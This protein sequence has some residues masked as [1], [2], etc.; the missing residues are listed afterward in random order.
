MAVKINEI[1]EEMNRIAPP[2]LAEEGDKIGFMVGDAE[3]FAERV[4][5]ALDA[6]ENVINEAIEKE[7]ELIITHHP[8]IY[9]PVSKICTD[10]ALGRKT[11]KLI[12][13]KMAVF[14]AHTNLDAADGGVNDTMCSLL[15]L[16]HVEKM[17]YESGT[18]IGRCGLLPQELTVG[19]LAEKLKN[20]LKCE[21]V[22]ICGDVNDKVEKV[23]MCCGGGAHPAFYKEAKQAECGCFI[24]GDARYHDLCEA[25]DIDMNVIDATHYAT[26]T[27]VLKT[28][29]EK[30]KSVFEGR[31]VDFILSAVEGQVFT[32]F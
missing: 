17:I 1:I 31:G 27:P 28:L 20:L 9:K 8:F 2:E 6:T 26:E 13:N 3:R 18:Y 23:G 21:F 10:D 24:T 22:R 32:R 15:G 5:V 19:E 25:K 4:L 7:A 12:E 30:L 14:S 16:D 29:I 11:L